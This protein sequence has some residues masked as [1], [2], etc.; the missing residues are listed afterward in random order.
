MLKEMTV[1][2]P[3]IGLVLGRIKKT[4]PIHLNREEDGVEKLKSTRRIKIAVQ[5]TPS[6]SHDSEQS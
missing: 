5:P 3:S 4:R 1:V 6:F 2:R